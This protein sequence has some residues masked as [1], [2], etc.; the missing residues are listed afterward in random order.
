MFD[1][2]MRWLESLRDVLIPEGRRSRTPE[3]PPNTPRLPAPTARDACA[4]QGVSAEPDVSAAESDATIE[5]SDDDAPVGNIAEI[6][7]AD[8]AEPVGGQK[9]RDD[10][11]T[12]SEESQARLWEWRLRRLAFRLEKLGRFGQYLVLPLD[13]ITSRIWLRTAR[14]RFTCNDEELNRLTRLADDEVV[15]LHAI[16]LVEIYTPNTL[17]GLLSRVEKYLGD[18]NFGAGEPGLQG[19][20]ESMR[21]RPGG[22]W[23][24]FPRIA[25]RRSSIPFSR[26]ANDLPSGISHVAPVIFSVTPSLTAL[27]AQFVLDNDTA[28][29]LTKTVNADRSTEVVR[30]KGG[31]L[32]ITY[33]DTVKGHAVEEVRR[34]LRLRGERWIKARFPGHFSALPQGRFPTIEFLTT[35]KATPWDNSSKGSTQFSR[36]LSALSLTAFN[37]YWTCNVFDYLHMHEHR[38]IFASGAD[39]H[40]LTLT[41]NQGQVESRMTPKGKKQAGDLVWELVQDFQSH[42]PTLATRW[43]ITA[44][45]TEIQRDLDRL[46]DLAGRT[47]GSASARDLRRLKDKLLKIGLDSRIVAMDVVGLAQDERRW[48]YDVPEFRMAGHKGQPEKSFEKVLREAQQ[49]AGHRVVQVENDL[50]EILSTSAELSAAAQGIRLQHV[51]LWLTVLSVLAAIVAAWAAVLVVWQGP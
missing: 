46:R 35:K 25:A 2:M 29:V 6:P 15:K 33:I 27:V 44:L 30:Q 45:L 13:A 19:W 9:V 26:T 32:G 18:G 34:D 43:A 40:I 42:V 49:A 7:A 16:W 11:N 10:G 51:V 50:R 39:A 23:R 37:N 4:S 48:C 14:S 41:A 47:I 28:D 17:P 38:N 5:P 1:A 31:S 8:V 24:A 3:A 21:Q 22:G 12:Q 20:V 36:G